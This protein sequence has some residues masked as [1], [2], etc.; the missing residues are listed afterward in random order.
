MTSSG[1]E[2]RIE[3]SYTQA[4]V[5]YPDLTAQ[6]VISPVFRTETQV[7]GMSTGLFASS[8]QKY[9]LIFLTFSPQSGLPPD[10]FAEGWQ[11]SAPDTLSASAS[12]G[13]APGSSEEEWTAL[14]NPVTV[15]TDLREAQ[16]SLGGR[17]NSHWRFG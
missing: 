5:V 3:S 12:M 13:F 10:L 6:H 8:W 16:A 1:N 7:N 17:C 9:P 4:L 11:I 14:I 15:R 2:E